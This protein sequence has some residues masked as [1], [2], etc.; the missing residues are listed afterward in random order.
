MSKYVWTV[1]DEIYAV[2]SSSEYLI[3]GSQTKFPIF[4]PMPL[5]F[6]FIFIKFSFTLLEYNSFPF[7]LFMD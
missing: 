6:F 1:L 2:L 7:Y 3:E 5:S 4:L